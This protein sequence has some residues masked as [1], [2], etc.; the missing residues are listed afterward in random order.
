MYAVKNRFSRFQ[1]LLISYLVILI[2]PVIVVGVMGYYL[3]HSFLINAVIRNEMNSINYQSKLL[4]QQLY[5]LSK[6]VYHSKQQMFMTEYIE[7]N[8]PAIYFDIKKYLSEN[9]NMDKFVSN[10]FFYDTKAKRIYSG[11]GTYKESYFFTNILHKE[12]KN[13][14][15]IHHIKNNQ[16]VQGNFVGHANDSLLYIVPV[17]KDYTTNLPVSYMLFVINH[18]IIE[19]MFQSIAFSKEEKFILYYM[20]EPFYST[21]LAV[22]EQILNRTFEKQ[23]AVTDFQ[24]RSDYYFLSPRDEFSLYM[25]VYV[26]KHSFTK[27]VY[28]IIIIQSLTIAAVFS[29][30]LILIF[31]MLKQNY[32][33]I[34]AIIN[35]VTK[36]T[37]K[38]KELKDEYT[39]IDNVVSDLLCDN[40]LL[41]ES[42][43]EIQKEKRLYQLLSLKGNISSSL[44]NECQQEG[45][46]LDYKNYFCFII[47]QISYETGEEVF[48]SEL[49]DTFRK[50]CSIYVL[51]TTASQRVYIAAGKREILDECYTGLLSLNRKTINDFYI[52]IGYIVRNVNRLNRS[53]TQAQILV[54]QAMTLGIPV[55]N[56]IIHNTSHTSYPTME[57]L[58]LKEAISMNNIDKVVFALTN[59][60]CFIKKN[61]HM[62]LSAFVLNDI[63][64]TIED[65]TSEQELDFLFGW[66]FKQ[67][68]VNTSYHSPED[69][70]E[71]IDYMIQIYAGLDEGGNRSKPKVYKRIDNVINFIND[72][73]R[74]ANF[75]LKYMAAYMD[76]TPSNLSQYF[77][78][79]TGENISDYIDSL[80]MGYAKS[81]LE[82]S[83]VTISCISS[84]LGY[85]NASAFIKKFKKVV[86]ITPGEY[87]M[88]ILKK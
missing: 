31:Y 82:Q 88:K 75:S 2:I 56:E 85:S 6:I 33:P 18:Q 60:K 71:K 12:M 67:N 39:L 66:D 9:E 25:V 7:E 36:A 15:M 72:K 57:F 40:K 10:I 46:L 48:F 51:K 8:M 59:L 23:Q 35:N 80:R 70:V 45:I 78:K 42:I 73:Y 21:D 3:I 55:C 26:N 14:V 24:K 30:G 81:M 76:T 69:I 58:V 44:R 5:Q 79:C 61:N 17:E 84:E 1:I 32:T 28:P 63:V 62:S 87:R 64:H 43:A 11:G 37:L 50:K 47:N 34:K 54:E 4:D 13:N 68:I 22:N 74:D 27:P 29:L 65:N 16:F 49:I 86:G 83:D 77:K 19:E 52:G 53:Y 38:Y 20:D 41:E